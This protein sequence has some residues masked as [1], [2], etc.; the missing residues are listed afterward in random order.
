MSFS[1][2]LLESREKVLVSKVVQ[3]QLPT[4][5]LS[6]SMPTIQHSFMLHIRNICWKEGFWI[7]ELKVKSK[8]V[9]LV[10][11]ENMYGR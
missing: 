3:P 9:I 2:C 7:L 5:L 11:I 8:S 4:V 10:I 6:S 1:R